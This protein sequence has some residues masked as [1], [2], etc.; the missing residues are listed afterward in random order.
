M[1][2]KRHRPQEIVTKLREAEVELNQGAT[3]E[4]VCRKLEISEPTFHRWRQ[5]PAP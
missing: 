3:V 2:R 5:K 4:A 1:K